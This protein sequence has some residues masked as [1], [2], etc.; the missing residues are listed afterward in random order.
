MSYTTKYECSE[1]SMVNM[2]AWGTGIFDNDDALDIQARFQRY[3]REGL[4]LEEVTYECTWDF[5]DPM[6]DVS[7]VLAL[8]ALQMEQGRLLPDIRQRALHMIEE[9]QDVALWREPDK[10]IRELE[11]FRQKLLRF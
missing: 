4:S 8:A 3:V 5:S 7:V 6:N 10:R 9:R 1:R 11:A 2:G